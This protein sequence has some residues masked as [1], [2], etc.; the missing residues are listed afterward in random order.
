MVTAVEL[1]LKGALWVLRVTQITVSTLLLC[2]LPG[3]A[4]REKVGHNELSSCPPWPDLEIWASGPLCPFPS[5]AGLRIESLSS[6]YRWSTDWSVPV[7]WEEARLI[8]IT[9]CSVTSRLLS[10]C[11]C[12]ACNRQLN[13]HS[14]NNHQHLSCFSTFHLSLESLCVCR[15]L[16]LQVPEVKFRCQQVCGR[17]D[18]K[19][20]WSG[21]GTTK[22]GGLRLSV[23][24]KV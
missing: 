19:T 10:H 4:W 7:I 17:W 15:A 6:H 23:K 16:Q 12:S 8:L 20:N 18:F 1:C 24:M 3:Y 11:T 13:I 21:I 2:S 9:N 5:P 14:L 22:T